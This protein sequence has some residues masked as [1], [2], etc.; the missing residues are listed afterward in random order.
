MRKKVD[1]VAVREPKERAICGL[2]PPRGS[3]KRAKRLDDLERARHYRK[4]Y[5]KCFD[6]DTV[7][8]GFTGTW[9]MVT[10]FGTAGAGE[11]EPAARAL[12]E[13]LAKGK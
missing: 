7:P 10:G 3:R 12:A 11:W 6:N 5:L 1:W 4:F 2:A 8:A 9:K 13:E